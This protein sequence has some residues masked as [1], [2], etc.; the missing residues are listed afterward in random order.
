MN[1]L[2]AV[3]CLSVSRIPLSFLLGD[4]ICSR[5]SHTI[6]SSISILYFC[7]YGH[8][9]KPSTRQ[10]TLG[11]TIFFF[12]RL[13]Y[14]FYTFKLRNSIPGKLIKNPGNTVGLAIVATGLVTDICYDIGK[15]FL[16]AC[17]DVLGTFVFAVS[18]FLI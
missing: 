9:L 7:I 4:N 16:M 18:N 1:Y 17:S 15:L 6:L 8:T 2:L 14:S 11:L 12:S 10:L 5:C 3:G 13:F